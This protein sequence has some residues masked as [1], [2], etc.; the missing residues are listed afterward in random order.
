[1]KKILY[2]LLIT[3]SVILGSCIIKEPMVDRPTTRVVVVPDG[4]QYYYR[5]GSPYYS[6]YYYRPRL[7]YRPA[8]PPPG[9]TVTPPPPRPPH[10]PA[11]TPPR[12]TVT[13]RPSH[14]NPPA[15]MPRPS[16]PSRTPTPRGN[17]GTSSS[18]YGHR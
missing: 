12:P 17:T 16:S 3:L 8:P 15:P 13:P 4:T 10:H 18:Y 7:P 1:M 14:A 5:Y 6:P 11:P 2:T 9:P